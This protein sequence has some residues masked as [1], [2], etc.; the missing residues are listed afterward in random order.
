MRA[1]DRQRVAP[2]QHVLAQPFRSGGVAQAG[3]ENVF[4]GRIAAREGIAD[5]DLVAVGREVPG[6]VALPQCDAE[7]FQ[8]GRHRRIDRLVGAFHVVAEFARQCRDAA[9]EGA[10]DTQNMKL[11]DQVFLKDCM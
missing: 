3:I 9:H 10:G 1:R 2:G 7:R 11:Q 8:L 6:L 5:D 4:D